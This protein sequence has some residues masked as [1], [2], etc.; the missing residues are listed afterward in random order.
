MWLKAGNINNNAL[1]EHV[2]M[3]KPEL[4]QLTIFPT[5]LCNYRCTSGNTGRPG[6]PEDPDT[7]IKEHLD[8]NSVKRFVDEILVSNKKINITLTGGEPLLYR[9]SNELLEFLRSRKIPV[10]VSSNGLLIKENAR[11]LVENTT[12]IQ[13]TA[14]GTEEYHDAICGKG[15]FKNMCEGIDALLEEKKRSKKRFPFLDLFMIITPYNYTNTL[16]FVKYIRERFSESKVVLESSVNTWLKARD[17]SISFEPVLFTTEEKGR[18]YASQM[19][20]FLKCDISGAWQSFVQDFSGMDIQWLKKSIEELWKAE[21]IDYSNFIDIYDYFYDIENLFGRSR[22]LAP[23]HEL[24]IHKNGDVYPC[25]DLPDYRLGNICETAFKD[26]WEGDRAE[27]FRT[28]KK[29]K[30]LSM[31]NRCSRLFT[32]YW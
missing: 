31:C 5:N 30:N 6:V 27:C 32:H 4:K 1:V 9:N 13:I 10:Q 17:L 12:V 15:S 28:L 25:S 3:L 16:D 24:T 7:V 18:E 26:I 14:F 22:C 23:W 2:Q 29:E 19:T 8:I 11:L 21:D 20:D